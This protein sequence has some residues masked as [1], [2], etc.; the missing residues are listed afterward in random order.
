ML[1][2]QQPVYV[3]RAAAP[4]ALVLA[5]A[6]CA[7]SVDPPAIMP[8]APPSADGGAE[9]RFSDCVDRIVSGGSS[10]GPFKIVKGADGTMTVIGEV[11]VLHAAEGAQ[12]RVTADRAE[13]TPDRLVLAGN[14]K[15]ELEGT[16]FTAARAVATH[17]A[18]GNMTITLED[19]IVTRRAENTETGGEP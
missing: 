12:S 10:A 8:A 3:L 1:A 11:L 14:V 4:T 5:I 17:D 6:A 7:T 15:L 16:S 9:S 13:H 19:A 18:D 2:R